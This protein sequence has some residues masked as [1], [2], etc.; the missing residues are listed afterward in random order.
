MIFRNGL[1]EDFRTLI[2]LID[3][4]YLF[5]NVTG[6]KQPVKISEKK[7]KIMKEILAIEE[8]LNNLIIL[9]GG[10]IED[11]ALCDIYT[12]N[13]NITDIVLNFDPNLPANL[14]ENISLLSLFMVH[15][16]LIKLAYDGELEKD[17]IEIYQSFV[18]PRELN[19]K[20]D[21]NIEIIKKEVK[22]L[23]N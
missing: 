15:C 22:K 11:E 4:D 19:N 18:Y 21:E 12:P 9:K 1:P 23:K 2:Y 16:K 5:T 3:N 13:K 6:E 8:N 7:M 17:N 20:I 10:I 14:P